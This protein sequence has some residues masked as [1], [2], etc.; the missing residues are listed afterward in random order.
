MGGLWT[1]SDSGSTF[2]L[3]LEL[4]SQLMTRT[5]YWRY[6]RSTTQIDALLVNGDLTRK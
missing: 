4:K 1:G 6:Y 2:K 5:D 3:A